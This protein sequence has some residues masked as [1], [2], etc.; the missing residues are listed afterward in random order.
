MGKRFPVLI[1]TAVLI[2]G[3]SDKQAEMERQRQE[4]EVAAQKEAAAKI[5]AEQ[6]KMKAAA[7]QAEAEAAKK[8]SAT[9]KRS[10]ASEGNAQAK[11]AAK[12]KERG[13]QETV[14]D[15]AKKTG[16]G[17]TWLGKKVAGGTTS[18]VNAVKPGDKT[19][20]ASR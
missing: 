6:A 12:D 14:V 10:R 1:A 18:T 3:C 2:V 13:F 19:E 7:E 17:V 5:A 4:A 15:S 8:R 9:V 11:S 20:P 16:K